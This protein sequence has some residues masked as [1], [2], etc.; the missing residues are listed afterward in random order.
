MHLLDSIQL[1]VFSFGHY[2]FVSQKLYYGE[3]LPFVLVK[4]D[5]LQH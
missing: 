4:S 3:H 5:N 1:N 2:H